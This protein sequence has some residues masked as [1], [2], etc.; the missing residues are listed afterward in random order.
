MEKE[1]LPI[2]KLDLQPD[3]PPPIST[4]A[5]SVFGAFADS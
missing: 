1:I 5:S 3:T 2:Y 4:A